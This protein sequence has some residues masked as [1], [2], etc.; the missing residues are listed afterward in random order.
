MSVSNALLTSR[1]LNLASKVRIRYDRK[2]ERFM[3]LYPERGLV[4][5]EIAAEVV[6]LCVS[7]RTVGAVIEELASRR[8]QDRSRLEHE[9]TRLLNSLLA[10]GLL[11]QES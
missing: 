3:L 6:R 5:D 1:R 7:G 10:R 9:V 11:H 2:A 8:G 4:L